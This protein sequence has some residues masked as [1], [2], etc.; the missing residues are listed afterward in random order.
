MDKKKVVV[1]GAGI[2][3]L[4][5]AYYFS[6]DK[7]FE[8]TLIE[9]RGE[10]GGIA[11]SFSHKDFILDHGP[12]K[13]YTELPGIIEEIS[14]ITPLLKVEKKNSIY[15][16]NNLFD[17]PLK[18]SQIATKMPL[19]AVSSGVDIMKKPL[20]KLLDDSYENYLLNRFGKTLY[21]LSFRDYSAKVWN[22]NPKDLDK[23]L[24]IR[25]VAISNIF[26]LIKG[27]LFKD[28]KNISVEYFYYPP[29]GIK[30]L[31]DNLV[32][33]IKEN[34]GKIISG[35]TI[36]EINI[37]SKKVEYVKIGN[38]KIKTDYVISTIY[39]DYLLDMIKDTEKSE[40]IQNAIK[41]LSYQKVSIL[42]IIL[43]KK[44]ALKDCWIFF[45]E[46]KFLFHRV[47]EQK[48]FSKETSPENKTALMVETTK[49]PTE[50]NIRVIVNQL[51][52]IGVLKQEDIEEYFVKSSPRVYPVYKKGFLPF[53]RKVVDYVD[54]ID[55]LFT[56]GRPGLFNYN[57]MD[58][59]W[60]MAKKTY[61]HINND[62][63]SEDWKKTKEYF[64]KYRI[65]D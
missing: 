42:Y 38:K 39:L 23:E 57:N 52:K 36:N 6:M 55:N 41:E 14:K 64:D 26:E 62:C 24:A 9:K 12:H 29:K 44:K 7:N 5:T 27:I 60:D 53:L 59:C 56:I 3:G 22:S 28:T 49:E 51:V 13:L 43:N 32:E 63:S 65:I 18:I 37:K 48:S 33:K 46:K 47:S 10:V 34:K 8:V 19:T 20:N 45:P 2:T 25:R 61:E 21:N 11:A 17:F 40:N 54:N 4:V 35:K 1:I 15:L 16:K 31:L 58:Q 50:E 30:Q